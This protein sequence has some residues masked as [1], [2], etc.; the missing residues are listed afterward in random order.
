MF[1]YFINIVS[2]IMKSAFSHS[3]KF[4][5]NLVLFAFFIGLGASNNLYSQSQSSIDKT[6]SDKD[7]AIEKL[8]AEGKYKSAEVLIDKEIERSIKQNQVG[9]FI[10]TLDKKKK[11]IQN[12]N[13]N[14]ETD[15]LWWNYLSNLPSKLN[16]EFNVFLKLR[17]AE[18]YK[19]IMDMRRWNSKDIVYDDASILP[20]NWTKKRLNDS[21]IVLVDVCMKSSES[22]A[23]KS[24]WY[25]IIKGNNYGMNLN[26]NQLFAMKCI[27]ILEDHATIGLKEKLD[28]SSFLYADRSMFL[29][30]NFDTIQMD[31]QLKKVMKLYQVFLSNPHPY[32]DLLRYQFVHQKLSQFDLYKEKLNQLLL[33]NIKDPLSNLFALELAN[34]EISRSKAKAMEIVEAALKRH[35]KSICDSE[36][37][38]LKKSLLYPSLYCQVERTVAPGRD[39]LCKVEQMNVDQIHI[40]IYKMDARTYQDRYANFYYND[41]KKYSIFNSLKNPVW[42]Q[43]IS[44]KKYED[45]LIHSAEFALDGLPEGSYMMV[46]TNGLSSTDENYILN[47]VL[48][49][50]SQYTY[51]EKN[52]T[53]YTLDA[54]NGAAVSLPYKWYFYRNNHFELF[55]EG[56]TD[57]SGKLELNQDTYGTFLLIFNRGELSLSKYFYISN[58]NESKLKRV[59]VLTDRNI[60]RP[61]QKIYFKLIAFDDY[62]KSVLK[63]ET[64]KLILNNYGSNL[65]YEKE[66]KTNEFG[67]YSDSIDIPEFGNLNGQYHFQVKTPGYYYSNETI[68]IENYKRP[69]FNVEFLKSKQMYKLG[70]S[71]KLTGVANALAGYPISGS[72]VYAMVYYR[73][74]VHKMWWENFNNFELIQND[75]LY[76]NSKGEFELNFLAELKKKND[77]Y[78]DFKIVSDVIDINGEQHSCEK[79]MSFGKIDRI[80][81]IEMPSE[82]ISNRAIKANVHHTNMESEDVPMTG[83]VKLY[84]QSNLSNEDLVE[85]PWEEAEEN[86]VDSVRMFGVFKD[87]FRQ[88]A[89]A[90]YTLMETRS[91]NIQLMNELVFDQMYFKTQGKYKLEAVSIQG[92]DTVRTE[93]LFNVNAFTDVEYQLDEKLKILNDNAEIHRIGKTIHVALLST[94]KDGVAKLVFINAFGKRTEQYVKLDG[95]IKLIQYKTNKSDLGILHIEAYTISKYRLYR[96]N[97]DIEIKDEDIIQHI[98]TYRSDLQAGAK[99]HWV[100]T[101]EKEQLKRMKVET[102]ANLYDA[103]LDDLMKGDWNT[104]FAHNNY[105][106]FGALNCGLNYYNS[107][108]ERKYSSFNIYKSLNFKHFYTGFDSYGWGFGNGM[109]GLLNKNE[110]RNSARVFK[111]NVQYFDSE[112][113]GD[114]IENNKDDRKEKEFQGSTPIQVRKN[115]NETVFFY[116]HLQANEQGQIHFDF[117]MPDALTKWKFRLFSHSTELQNEYTELFVTTSKTLMIQAN[118]PRFLRNNDKISLPIKLVN[119]SKDTI[120]AKFKMVLKNARSGEVLNWFVDKNE[121]SILMP[122]NESVIQTVLLTIPNFHES[123]VVAMELVSEHFTDAEERLLPVLENRTFVTASLPITIRKKGVKNLNF[124]ALLNANSQTLVHHSLQVEMCSNPSWYVLRALPGL[125]QSE[126]LSTDAIASNLFASSIALKLLETNPIIQ[127]TLANWKIK[128]KVFSSKLNQNAELKNVSIGETPWLRAS[129]TETAQMQDLYNFMQKESLQR[130]INESIDLLL[131]NQNSNGSFSWFKGMDDNEYITQ[132]VL[133]VFAKMKYL[134]V[135]ITKCE[136]MLKYALEYLDAEMLKSYKKDIDNKSEYI[137]SSQIQYLYVQAMLRD[138]GSKESKKV[139]KH[140]LNQAKQHRQQLNML[141]LAQLAVASYVLED[142]SELSQSI[143][144]AFDEQ[145]QSNEEMGMFWPK[146]AG[147]F[148]WYDSPIETQANVIM[149]YMMVDRDSVKIE[150]QK[151]WLLRQKQTQSWGN[152]R[153]TTEA[154]FVL[155]M[156]GE[157]NRKEQEV[158]VYINNQWVKPEVVEEGTGYY[159]QGVAKEAIKASSGNVK[160]ESNDNQFA[161]GAVYWQYFED[162]DKIQSNASGLSIQR[163]YYKIVMTSEGEQLVELKSGEALKVG[164]RLR[165]MLKVSSDR[166]MEYIQIKDGRASGTE[167]VSVISSYHYSN[168]LWYYQVTNDY[169]TQFFVERM[170]RGNY[171]LTYDLTVQQNGVFDAGISSVQCYYAPE[172]SA[173]G[174]GFKLRVE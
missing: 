97:L 144:E 134:K 123:V 128:S 75:T 95:N 55:K 19:L 40:L 162:N 150:N 139:I 141:S 132:S 143:V 113:D 127:K 1:T 80:I 164:D 111:G 107:S 102:L 91:Y 33:N 136:A 39:I 20:N 45:Y 88:K 17:V 66:I 169:N 68:Q 28:L 70:D 92:K 50:S 122:A 29:K 133:M 18:E 155:L 170:E 56:N 24:S 112:S 59:N 93:K 23:I 35:S 77:S 129:K 67:S 44:L 37:K 12:L 90:S 83:Y 42:E 151:L 114:G 140:Y 137:S 48:I 142:N 63:F 51:V 41:K 167:P 168:G 153:S 74:G 47:H 76:T 49:Q 71:V 120:Q 160:V 43:K 147:G 117:Q 125:S 54:N 100:I 53:L 78:I 82:S 6:Y 26:A 156:G 171:Q 157:L 34:L 94:I 85:R 135:D 62:E 21:V 108:T 84:K 163:V 27:N 72:K 174:K 161:Y 166:A 9:H 58:N 172:F 115:F 13:A 118:L 46:L 116:P 10:V 22:M 98:K 96:T 119:T 36:L 16:D 173:N 105:Y 14:L 86:W 89:I 31:E 104:S 4:F 101:L 110:Y 7:K 79:I 81:N 158:K 2:T 87:Y 121:Y 52:N 5:L 30:Y 124:T 109:V 103:S 32:S 8:L 15:T 106:N 152:F 3:Y 73:S 138:Y 154:C 60:Y 99:E 146:N 130:Q 11:V 145:S 159:K 131:Q 61:G 65:L 149:A 69:S 165:V 57:S 25:P 126:N 64:L 148:Y 38:A